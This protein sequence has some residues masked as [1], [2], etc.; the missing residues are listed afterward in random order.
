MRDVDHSKIISYQ[1]K[2]VKH[3]KQLRTLYTA[4]RGNIA[5]LSLYYYFGSRASIHLL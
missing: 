5:I 4:M 3:R 2:G 1:A